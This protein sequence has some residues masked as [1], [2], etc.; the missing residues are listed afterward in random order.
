MLNEKLAQQLTAT[1][2]EQK[3]SL[4]HLLGFLKN[5]PDITEFLNHNYFKISMFF[6]DSPL[7]Q[8]IIAVEKQEGYEINPNFIKKNQEPVILE[9]PC[10]HYLCL[11]FKDHVDILSQYFE[12]E[13]FKMSY[14]NKGNKKYTLFYVIR[15]FKRFS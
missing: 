4:E 2:L 13:A 3:M 11:Q 10:V 6:H 7:G 5:Y 9:I 8:H 1:I 12:I 15:L 14:L